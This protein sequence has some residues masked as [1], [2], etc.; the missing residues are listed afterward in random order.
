MARGGSAGYAESRSPGD[1]T[2]VPPV[3]D[4]DDDDSLVPSHA[5][6]RKTE[7]ETMM[8]GTFHRQHS[9]CKNHEELFNYT[10]DAGAMYALKWE[11]SKGLIRPSMPI[12]DASILD[13]MQ[14]E[15]H[16]FKPNEGYVGKAFGCMEPFVLEDVAH[17]KGF[18]RANFGSDRVPV[19]TIVWVPTEKKDAVI[20]IGFGRVLD[21]LPD[22]IA[23]QR[24]KS[25][26]FHPVDSKD[27]LRF[28]LPPGILAT[29]KAH[30]PWATEHVGMDPPVLEEAVKLPIL[31]ETS[32]LGNPWAQSA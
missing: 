22:V 10:K 17:A 5:V 14:W 7:A 2:G 24:P 1:S 9:C 4:D 21:D 31:L 20:E 8:P 27:A 30:N 19:R 16:S 29:L 32:Y 6:R 26:R 15:I 12:G 25:L 18:I 13:D 28:A 23:A 3:Q 11:L